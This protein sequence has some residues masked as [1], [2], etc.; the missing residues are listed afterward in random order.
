MLSSW[1]NVIIWDYKLSSGTTCYHLGCNVIIWNLC[2]HLWQNAIIWS[3]CYNG[4]IRSSCYHLVLS[5]DVIIW[6]DNTPFF[7]F[8][9]KLHSLHRNRV[10]CICL[11]ILLSLSLSSWVQFSKAIC[12]NSPFNPLRL[13]YNIMNPHIWIIVPAICFLGKNHIS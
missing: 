1:T 2:Y 8:S 10:K 4:I 6:D 5:C 3:L 11:T 12:S 7:Y 9:W 13:V